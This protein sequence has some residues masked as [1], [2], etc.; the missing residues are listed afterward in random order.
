[1]TNAGSGDV[2]TATVT[3]AC[4]PLNCLGGEDI[5]LS[6]PALSALGGSTVLPT[7]GEDFLCYG[8]ADGVRGC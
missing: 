3:D 4:A 6:A 2:V 7:R 1:M 8:F 5:A